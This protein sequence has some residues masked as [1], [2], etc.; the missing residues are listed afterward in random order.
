MRSLLFAQRGSTIEMKGSYYINEDRNLPDRKI[1]GRGVLKGDYLSLLYD[2]ETA[3]P[4]RATTHGA[5]LLRIYP[6]SRLVTGYYLTRSMAND[7]IVFGSLEF[8]R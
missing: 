6:S 8:T 4:Q 7:G 2:I 3:S 5:M 1:T